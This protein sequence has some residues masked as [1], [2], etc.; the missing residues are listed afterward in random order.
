M[1]IPKV[2]NLVENDADCI[3][4]LN[5]PIISS[6]ENYHFKYSTLKNILD[7]DDEGIYLY[8]INKALKKKIDVDNH[9]E[10]EII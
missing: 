5:K 9:T 2:K 1:D 3:K 10:E 7:T 8:W 4:L 6:G